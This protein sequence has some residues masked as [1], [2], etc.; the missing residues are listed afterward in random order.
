VEL[1]NWRDTRGTV[2]PTFV[3]PDHIL[4]H[5]NEVLLQVFPDYPVSSPGRRL[6]CRVPQHTLDVVFDVLGKQDDKGKQAVEFPLGWKA[7]DG[8]TNAVG[9]FVGYLLLD[10]W[11]GNTDRHHE[12]WGLVIY[13]GSSPS[14]E[15]GIYLA[16]TFDHASSLGRNESDESRR[17]RLVTKDT[18]FYV[19]AYV[20]KTTSALYA[21][22]G[23]AKPKPLGTLE[24]F[25]LAAE[26][27]PDSGKV[28]LDRLAA[29]SE[30]DTL[31]LFERI[32]KK[33]ITPTA[34]EF[35]QTMLRLNRQR[36]LGLRE[37]L[38]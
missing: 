19:S 11:I 38:S 28:W 37:T 7:P 24:A 23:D 21:K 17:A 31:Q 18:G 36:L 30:Q 2:S 20:E 34:V 12:N 25:R 5:G 1:G 3:K 27:Y 35:A 8:I 16:P 22:S 32:P 29:V 33:R 13:L 15:G 4:V 6:F 10:A 26:R 14:V 9:V